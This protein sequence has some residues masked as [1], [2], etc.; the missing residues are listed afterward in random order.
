MHDVVSCPANKNVFSPAHN[1]PTFRGGGAV[2]TSSISVQGCFEKDARLPGKENSNSTIKWIR[3]RNLSIKV[4]SCPANR[5]VF[6]PAHN[7][8]TFRGEGAVA[9][10]PISYRRAFESYVPGPDITASFVKR[11]V[12][13]SFVKG[14]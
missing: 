2:A 1:T 6:R 10:S 4:V 11:D 8:P 5:N 7:I 3:T 14:R 13:A 9:T 12:T